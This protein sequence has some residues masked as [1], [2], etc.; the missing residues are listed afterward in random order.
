[1]SKKKRGELGVRQREWM[2][3]KDEKVRL[4]LVNR[5]KRVEKSE[6]SPREKKEK[7]PCVFWLVGAA[8]EPDEE[9]G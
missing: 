1:M 4:W 3:G 9:T 7:R 5:Q 2:E 6:P 8:D